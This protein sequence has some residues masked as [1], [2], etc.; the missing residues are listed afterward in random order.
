MSFTREAAIEHFEE[1]ERV[2][3]ASRERVN[4]ENRHFVE[5]HSG[6]Y[7]YCQFGVEVYAILRLHSAGLMDKHSAALFLTKLKRE[8]MVHPDIKQHY[9]DWLQAREMLLELDR[10]ADRLMS[11]EG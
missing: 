6:G 11:A 5:D 8:R 9:E 2:I 1:M 10:R 4:E 7:S 3:L